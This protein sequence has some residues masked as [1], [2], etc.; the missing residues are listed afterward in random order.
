MI[1]NVP[2]AAGNPS[3]SLM[4]TP[5]ALSERRCRPG[6]KYCRLESELHARVQRIRQAVHN[7]RAW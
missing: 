4:K 7:I 1:L 3:E 5:L 6:T 2:Q